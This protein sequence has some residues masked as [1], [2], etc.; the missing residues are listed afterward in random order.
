MQ[1]FR[2]SIILSMSSIAFG[3]YNCAK[4]DSTG[5]C[6]GHDGDPLDQPCNRLSPC[7]PPYGNPCRP[8][9]GSTGIADC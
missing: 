9:P 5:R 6:I 8:D 2:F 7:N 1:I 4:N 3:Y